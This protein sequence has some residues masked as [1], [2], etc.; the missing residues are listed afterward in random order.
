MYANN[1]W[2]EINNEYIVVEVNT[3][4]I[5]FAL[6]IFNYLDQLEVTSQGFS[7][8]NKVTVLGW[9]IAAFFRVRI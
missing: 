1:C 6:N 8:V 5:Y 9:D 7:C 4:S 3:G 2:N